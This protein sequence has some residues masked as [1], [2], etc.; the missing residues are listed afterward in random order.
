MLLIWWIRRRDE[1]YMSRTVHKEAL[2][3][4][5]YLTDFT[6]MNNVKQ[7]LYYFKYRNMF[8]IVIMQC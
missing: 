1:Q 5:E 6:K 3:A 4:F 2:T 7:F 8:G